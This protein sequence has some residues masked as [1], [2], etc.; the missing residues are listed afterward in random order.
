MADARALRTVRLATVRR[1]KSDEAWR[2]AITD[3]LGYGC[4]T[5][6]V[7]AAAG[8]SHTRVQQIRDGR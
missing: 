7:A 2:K 1:A 4:S 3:A 5:R 8:I 6:E